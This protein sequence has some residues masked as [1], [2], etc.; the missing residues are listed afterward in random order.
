MTTHT[1]LGVRPLSLTVPL[2]VEK[3]L[4]RLALMNGGVV[5]IARVFLELPLSLEEVEQYADQVADGQSV[6]KD[7][8][9]EFLSYQF[10]ELEGANVPPETLDDCPVCGDALPPAPTQAGQPVR[11]PIICEVCFRAVKRLNAKGP[12]TGVM[13]RVRKLWQNEEE[14]DPVQVMLTEH[15]IFYLALRLGLA[16]FTQTTLAA[17]SRLPAT[18]LKERL[19]SMAARRYIHVGLVPTGDAVGYRLPPDLDY[20]RILYERITD[21]KATSGR[22]DVSVEGAAPSAPQATPTP[23]PPISIR[24]RTSKK[25][26]NIRIKG[27]RERGS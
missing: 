27:R 26:L 16:Q 12:D 19:D 14:K 11:R 8:W 6:L 2:A 24:S 15:E 7:E 22:M 4:F 5:P 10:P 17:Q 23:N 1:E 20:P 18:Q 25:K 9:A 13:D 21:R 3:V